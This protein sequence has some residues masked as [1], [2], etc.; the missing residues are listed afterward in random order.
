MAEADDGPVWPWLH[1]PKP[2]R[3]KSFCKKG[4][5]DPKNEWAHSYQ[6]VTEE[7]DS[8]YMPIV[9]FECQVCG[10]RKE[11]FSTESFM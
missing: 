4:V 1:G 6:Y 3:P 2:I 11:R 5:P 7:L 10:K 8:D 9:V